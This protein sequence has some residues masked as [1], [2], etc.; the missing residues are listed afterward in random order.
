MSKN[1]LNYLKYSG[2]W[3]SFALNPYHWR[4]SFDNTTPDDMDPAMYT[5]TIIVG[6]LT[7]RVVLDN[8]S[9]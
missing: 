7:I 9:W 4:I 1:L 6:P 2:V 8:G 5:Y 3:I